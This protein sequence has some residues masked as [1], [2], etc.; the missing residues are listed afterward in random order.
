MIASAARPR[1][2]LVRFVRTGIYDDTGTARSAWARLAPDERSALLRIHPPAAFR[3]S[4]AAHALARSMLARLAGCPP[5]QL[6]FQVG[7]R[8]RPDP[9]AP[10]K[11]RRLR[12][13]LSHADG[14]AL[15]AVAAGVPVGA[16][17][18][19]RRN[20]GPDPVGVAATICS[21]RERETLVALPPAERV[22]RFLELW[23]MKEAIAKAAG[24]GLTVPL[25]H[26]RVDDG[27]PWQVAIQWLT[28]DHLAAVA[29]ERGDGAFALLCE[30]ERAAVP[31]PLRRQESI[32]AGH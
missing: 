19:S 5:S 28:P 1:E 12:I 17:V 14:I 26:L 18:E 22:D 27:S 13:S 7:A 10:P 11:A 6:R 2:V 20:V 16:D 24:H 30:E 32:D 15:C 9:I 21:S 23:T 4:L 25:H 31:P 8:G 29:I 3:D